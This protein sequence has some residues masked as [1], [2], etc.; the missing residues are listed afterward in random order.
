VILGW[1]R[2]DQGFGGMVNSWLSANPRDLKVLRG[3]APLCHQID[4]QERRKIAGR[5]RGGAR[6][7]SGRERKFGPKGPETL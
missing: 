6:G 3:T 7:P 2:Q 4:E 5:I 1:R